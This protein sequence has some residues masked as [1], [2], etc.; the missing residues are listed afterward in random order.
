MSAESCRTHLTLQVQ[1]NVAG[2]VHLG[3]GFALMGQHAA[4]AVSRRRGSSQHVRL[5]S[6]MKTRLQMSVVIG[7]RQLRVQG[8]KIGWR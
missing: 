8:T 6:M 2:C 3:F 7:R 4:V 5:V 1:R